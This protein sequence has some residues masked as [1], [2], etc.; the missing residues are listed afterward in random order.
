MEGIGPF[1]PFSLKPASAIPLKP[2]QSHRTNSPFKRATPAES[3]FPAGVFI[4]TEGTGFEP[5]TPVRGISFPMR[6]LAI[7]LP[8]NFS[9]GG[10]FIPKLAFYKAPRLSFLGD[11]TSAFSLRAHFDCVDFTSTSLQ[12]HFSFTSASLRFLSSFISPAG[13]LPAV[14]PNRSLPGKTPR[15]FPR[16][17]PVPPTGHSGSWRLKSTGS[18]P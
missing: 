14:S 1:L 10:H 4:S 2:L 13:F 11:F 18:L 17:H 8:S 9:N 12:L 15:P 3:R 7:R 16:C 6:L 5:A